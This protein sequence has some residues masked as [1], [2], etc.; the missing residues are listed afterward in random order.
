MGRISSIQTFQ[1]KKCPCGSL[2]NKSCCKTQV[3]KF[4]LKE[5]LSKNPGPKILSQGF[6]LPVVFTLTKEFHPLSVPTLDFNSKEGP[7]NP[8][9]S[10]YIQFRNFRV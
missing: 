6:E 4:S 2:K 9:Q 8:T 5:A 1:A 7:P 3:I 10:L